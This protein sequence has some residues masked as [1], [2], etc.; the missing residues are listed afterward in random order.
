MWNQ[1]IENPL[2]RNKMV[3]RQAR[4]PIC[5]DNFP[6]NN[7]LRSHIT[8]IHSHTDIFTVTDTNY[9]SQKLFLCRHCNNNSINIYLTEGNL[10]RHIHT[11]HPTA[12]RTTTNIELLNQTI[13]NHSDNTNIDWNDALQF[14][15]NVN[16]NKPPP[17]RR[18]A[19]SKI[20]KAQKRKFI[21]LYD[22]SIT[23]LTKASIPLSANTDQTTSSSLPFWK[24]F[25]I[26]EALILAPNPPNFTAGTY[27]SN[28]IDLFYKGKLRQLY[29]E[30]FHRQHINKPQQQATVTQQQKHIQNSINNDDYKKA[31][32]QLNT[33][34]IASIT[35]ENRHIIDKLYPNALPTLSSNHQTR[36][37]TTHNISHI[38]LQAIKE[39]CSDKKLITSVNT[40]KR[41]KAPGPFADSQEVL[42]W[43]ALMRQTND[44]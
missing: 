42:K 39:L 44:T 11:K 18:T 2:H 25:F 14:L 3:S 10:K 37:T 21:V 33:L 7:H 41:G 17:F 30:A 40:I 23:L 13:P 20:T 32:S 6:S 4:C 35:D 9:H 34:P 26:I 36:S 22:L 8:Q 29:N 15:T 5:S 24:L 27:L 16:I 28:R 31:M 43:W 1:G 19:W 12:I 38:Q